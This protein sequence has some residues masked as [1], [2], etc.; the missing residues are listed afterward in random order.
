MILLTGASG[1]TG[2]YLLEALL[3]SGE[4]PVVAWVRDPARLRVSHPRLRIWS[5]GLEAL[6]QR[7]AELARV[8]VLIHAATAW[9]GPETFEVNTRLAWGMLQALDP[10]VCLH[11][12]IFS[13]ASL[14]DARQRFIP[15]SLRLGSDYIRSKATLH[16]RLDSL[17]IPLSVYYPTVI[18]GGDARHP[19]TAASADLPTFGNWLRALRWLTA[20]GRLHL[21]HA[22]DIAAILSARIQAEAAPARLVLGNPAI[23]VHD[24]IAR[25]L[26]LYG[27]PPAPLRL[28][29][30]P[31][32]PILLPLLH[33][34]MSDW[35]RYSLAHRDTAYQAVKAAD[36]GLP[37]DLESL[38]AMVI[39]LLKSRS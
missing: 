18:L 31:L 14:L 22:R 25:L 15:A 3:A 21:I 32:L 29:L 37:D 19:Y 39:S 9:G 24:L 12:H 6:P 36:Y 26:P 4:E 10:A 7:R 13:T 2:S 33:T 17:R 11:A 30:D 5:G 27:I 35:D 23:R 8:R 16:Q 34:R 38:E 20:T 1:C 28:P